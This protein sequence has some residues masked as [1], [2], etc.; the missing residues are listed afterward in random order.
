MLREMLRAEVERRW[1][2]LAVLACLCAAIP[3]LHAVRLRDVRAEWFALT[4]AE[5]A[6]LTQAL[7]W[8]LV[9]ACAVWGFDT[10]SHERR[11]GW[12][13]AL[14]LPV[15][16]LRLFSLRYVVGL[17]CLCAAMS[18]LLAAA[19]LA[20]AVVALPAGMYAYPAQFSLWTALAGWTLYTLGFVVGARSSRPTATVIMLLVAVAAGLAVSGRRTRPLPGDASWRLHR[21]SAPGLL[22]QPPRLFDY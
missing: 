20:A 1:A 21:S 11:S 18:A 13:Y 9:V 2:A 4:Y 7:F 22:A 17:A 8:T 12:V 6:L 14:S 19:Y 15:P 3:T 16:R 10:W 5:T